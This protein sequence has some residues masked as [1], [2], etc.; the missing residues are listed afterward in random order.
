M[1]RF[2]EARWISRLLPRDAYTAAFCGALLL[3]AA[4][5]T[6]G[7]PVYWRV[8]GKADKTSTTT[9]MSDQTFSFTILP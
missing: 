5:G 6:G 7:A 2:L 4:L 9:L 8:V 3:F 1:R